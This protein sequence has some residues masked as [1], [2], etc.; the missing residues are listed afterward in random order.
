MGAD[1]ALGTFKSLFV[2][3]FLDGLGRSNPVSGLQ[4]PLLGYGSAVV[5]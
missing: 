4:F 3:S 1:V 5:R 2:T